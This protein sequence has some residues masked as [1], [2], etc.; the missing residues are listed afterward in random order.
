LIPENCAHCG[1]VLSGK[2]AQPQC[3]QWMEIPE[4]RPTVIEYRL[5]SLECSQCGKT[6]KT[7]PPV[8]YQAAF[9]PNVHAFI[10]QAISVFRF[11]R[12]KLSQIL[13]EWFGL[14]IATG[15]IC[16]VQKVIS[17]A[18]QPAMREIRKSIGKS[19]KPVN[20]DET[21]FRLK[22]GK[23]WLWHAG[24]EDASLFLFDKHRSSEA[25]K[26]ILGE[27]KGIIIT[28]R[29]TAYSYWEKD[30]KQWC[31]AHLLRDFE[32]VYQD[33]NKTSSIGKKLVDL[34]IRLLKQW[35]KVRSGA[36]NRTEFQTRYLRRI[37]SEV[38]MLLEKCVN[39][40][41]MR[42][43]VLAK[44]LLSCWDS[45]WLFSRVDGVEPTNNE[46]ERQLRE[47]VIYRKICHGVK[48]DYGAQFLEAMHSVVSTCAKQGKRAL[49]FL[50]DSM[51]AFVNN[52]PT[53]KLLTQ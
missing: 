6:T 1:E 43:G 52:T 16:K 23:G 34:G 33:G 38:R 32:A 24:N 36:M 22:D 3:H 42:I 46:A 26:N 5:H 40:Q 4:I 11:S 7:E 28:D 13:R 21:S 14:P 50:S 15:T 25:A 47:L 17:E 30:K 45:L 8:E 19:G 29:F 27:H 44:K 31:W 49:D 35:T 39:H 41:P 48:S 20:V 9:G 53:P 2:N 10:G 51:R 12:R 37:R 18:V